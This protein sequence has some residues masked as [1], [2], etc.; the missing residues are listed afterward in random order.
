MRVFY[1]SL[2]YLLLPIVVLRLYWRG[3]KAPAYRLRWAERFGFVARDLPSAATLPVIWLH[4][5]SVG[6]T[7]AALPLIEQLLQRYPNHRLLISTST[8][9]GSAQVKKSL[10]DRVWHSYAPYDLPD[11]VYRFLN[12]VRPEIMIIMETELWP[13]TIAA[14]AKRNIP[15][16]LAN[17]RLSE[18][19]AKGYRRLRRISQEMLQNL[20][21]LAG[22]H[23]D[24][25]ARFIA[26]GLPA[27]RSQVTGNIKFDLTRSN[28]LLSTAA[29]LKAQWSCLGER[30]V[31]LAASTHRGED[32][33]I[34]TAFAAVRKACPRL[35]LV[36][37]PRHPER[38]EEVLN[39]S[40]RQFS[41]VSCR[42]LKEDTNP[43][44]TPEQAIVVADTMGEM[45]SLLGASDIVF[46][47]GSLVSSGGHNM[48]EP[49]HWGL[50][51][52]S[53][54]SL[55]NFAEASRLLQQADAMK[56]I[57]DQESF[58]QNLSKLCLEPGTR[59]AMGKRAM[60]VAESN[61]GALDK[62]L[63]IIDKVI[64]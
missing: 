39:L 52:L 43:A 19:S 45:M 13:N 42:S 18:K 55:Y 25:Q 17:A 46:V 58:A 60:S 4:A 63:A 23:E 54:P 11:S 20:S 35:L 21:Y 62:L 5:V 64:R 51:I 49:A 33:Q 44:N 1:S 36:L 14:C 16:I 47:G 53:G 38:F 40:R 59:L 61:R 41:Q 28:E 31:F 34:L 15:V 24:D 2:F 57:S 30:I 29:S 56:I 12:R 48:I 3:R 37:V 27:E 6:E 9:T 22:Q 8:P 32:E 26:L 10:G 50:P 7:V